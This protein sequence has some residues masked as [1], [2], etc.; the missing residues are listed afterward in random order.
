MNRSTARNLAIVAG[1]AASM[2][3]AAYGQ[4]V[5]DAPVANN[6]EVIGQNTI[7]QVDIPAGEDGGN[8]RLLDTESI[9]IQARILNST[10]TV[11]LGGPFAAVVTGAPAYDNAA[12]NANV[13]ATFT[14]VNF[15]GFLAQG[16][17]L[18]LTARTTGATGEDPNTDFNI[19]GLSTVVNTADETLDTSFAIDTTLPLLQNVY[20]S[21]DGNNAFFVFNK[22]MNNGVA[23]N[24]IN[25]TVI[26][27]IDASDFEVDTTNSFDGSEGAPTG[28]TNPTFVGDSRSVI[29]FDR[30]SGG[31]TLTNGSF[32]RPAFTN[33]TPP[34][35]EHSLFDVVRGTIIVPPNP[36]TGVT[37]SAAPALA[38]SS[39]E[40]VKVVPA[41]GANVTGALRVIFSSPINT[42]GSAGDF[43]LV[44]DGDDIGG[45]NLSNFTVDPTNPNAILIDVDS[46]NNN[47]GVA[48]DGRTIN[49]N[50]DSTGAISV[51]VLND[52]NGAAITD[53]FANTFTGPTTVASADRIAPSVSGTPFFVDTNRDGE[54]DG[55][56]LAFNEPIGAIS[57]TNGF[58]L[59]KLSGN[60]TP[61]FQISASEP[62]LPDAVARVL[63]GT[64][65]QNAI[66]I[67]AGSFSVPSTGTGVSRISFNTSNPTASTFT[68]RQTN[69]AILVTFDPRAVDWDNDTTTRASATP[70]ANEPVPG[71]G[72]GSAFDLFFNPTAASATNSLTG[73]S[74][75]GVTINDANNNALVGAAGNNAAATDG[76][77]PAV[78]AVIFTPG[79]NQGGGN[80]DQFFRETDGNA[81]DQR[82]NDRLT[83][84]FGENL[85]DF[86]DTAFIRFGPGG[87]SGGFASG[88]QVFMTDNQFAIAN[89]QSNPAIV[90][91]VLTRILP[92]AGIIDGFNNVVSTNDLPSVARIAPYVTL[93]NVVDGNATVYAAYLFDADS[94]S[95]DAGF[96]FADS[97][98]ITMSQ[99]VDPATVQLSDFVVSSGSITAA[100]VQGSDIV[101]TLI[102]SQV[103]MTST[104][105]LTYNAA[106]DSTRIASTGGVEIDGD[107]NNSVT[108]QQIPTPDVD[109]QDIAVMDIVG[110]I[111]TNGTTPVPPGT[112]IYAMIAV[113]TVVQI[114][115]THNNAAFYVDSRRSSGSEAVDNSAY[116]SLESFTN[117]LLGLEDY[118]YLLRNEQNE[119]DYSN[120]KDADLS[121]RNDFAREVIQLTI[122]ATNLASI[123]FTGRGETST[124][125]V[126]NG[127]V[128]LAWDVLR[129]DN[130]TLDSL[131]RYGVRSIYNY[132]APILSS[133]VIT[134]A[135]GRFKLHVTAPAP[136]FTGNNRLSGLAR[137]V[138]L[139][140]EAPGGERTAVSSLLSSVNGA[141]VLFTAQ[142]RTQQTTG[143]Q[144]NNATTF[145]INLNNVGREQ[146][147]TGW[148]LLPFNRQGGWAATAA[149][150][151]IRVAELDESEIV[152]PTAATPLPMGATAVEQ[153]VMWQD[154]NND[155]IWTTSDEDGYRFHSIIIDGDLYRFFFFTMGSI[156]VQVGS[157]INNLVGGYALGA[158][159][160][161]YWYGQYGVFQFGAPFTG[162]VLFP[163][164]S[165]TNTFPNNATTQGW[166]LFT[167]KSGYNP[168]TTARGSSTNPKLDYVIYFRNNGSNATSLGLKRIEIQTLDLVPESGETDPQDLQTLP[169]GQGFFGHQQ[170]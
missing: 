50:G 158:F 98:R 47:F 68:S 153:F 141:P 122:N 136:V 2:S 139:V 70:D 43:V 96:G 64:I 83:Y 147:H 37:I 170:P 13:Q 8:D 102:D 86:N 93:Q 77:A 94:V 36:G 116:R 152:V 97:I 6:I 35:A 125:Q 129:S 56:V 114:T 81:G 20:V 60:S 29:R 160:D 145:N 103:P 105:T 126:T 73:T 44:V 74:V 161:G 87:A 130:G 46:D 32:V 38:V 82:S 65:A 146:I 59:T 155:G 75:P 137:P 34:V 164:T 11:V 41:N 119:Q 168:A 3:G 120:T 71:T 143:G 76:A 100:A 9:Q 66:T 28:L 95:T 15:S 42:T 166:G 140:V 48:A 135:D 107:T 84:I 123:T 115:A 23:A 106:G 91:G 113:P 163:A 124:Q 55:V 18:V 67:G 154:Y 99:P 61:F 51:R 117:Y 19:V 169:A 4:L 22:S 17:I 30:N 90:P 88:A 159:N 109:S 14:G 33:A 1:L 167:A 157:G 52:G 40:W 142:N 49:S 69:S 148:N 58:Q 72:D 133:A 80:N 39:S 134:G 162:N 21:S 150:R 131:Y 138:I 149:A 144:A 26:G 27:N 25:H 156:G 110:T 165:A 10:G 24:D 12:G 121:S 79:D 57:G 54:L 62:D 63:S 128:A 7:V 16:N 85:D 92:G 78:A 89:T 118:V 112:K 101:L 31:T 5:I 108:V 127:K 53:L 132:G 151:P 45:V 104:L 111:T